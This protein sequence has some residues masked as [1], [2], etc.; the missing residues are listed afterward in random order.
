[1]KNYYY[2]DSSN[3]PKGPHTLEQLSQLAQEGA[4]SAETMLAAE[5]DPDWKSWRDVSS[6]APG[7]PGG[8]IPTQPPGGTKTGGGVDVGRTAKQAVDAF[9]KFA[10]DPVGGL[11]VACESLDNSSALGVGVAFCLAF[12]AC[13]FVVVQKLTSLPVKEILK[14]DYILLG[15]TPFLCLAASSF[16]ARNIFRGSGRIGND[17]F[18]AGAALLPAGFAAVLSAFLGGGNVE[19]A[20]L[21]WVFVICITIMI[22]YAGCNRIAKLTERAATFAVPTMLCISAFIAKVLF[23]NQLQKL[24][25]PELLEKG[26]TP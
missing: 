13:L 16:V 8:S 24:V 25:P 12:M 26:F 10:T 4:I 5:G 23:A 3:Q 11:P 6:G 20:V 19:V 2:L 15:A 7:V 18:V 14:L 22:L 17:C 1:M 21:L 9:K